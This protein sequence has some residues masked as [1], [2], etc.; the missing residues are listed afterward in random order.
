MIRRFIRYYKPHIKMFSA[1]M[2]CAFMLALCSLLLPNVTRTMINDYIPN[3]R[4]RHL[5]IAAGIL[6]CAYV[7]KWFLNY[8]IQYYGHVVGVRMQGQMR[9]EMFQKI[10]TLPFSFYDNNKTGALMSRMINDLFDVSE[11]AYHGPEDIFVSAVLLIGSFVGMAMMDIWLTLIIFAFIPFMLWFSAK[12]RVKMSR[13]FKRSREEVAEVN[14]TLENSISGV[15]VSKAF[16]N[17]DTETEKFDRNNISFM[18]SRK[19]AYKVMAEFHAG[20]TLIIDALYVVVLLAGGLFTYY[21]RINAG[22]FVAY[23]LYVSVFLDPIR[24]IIGFIE[25][26]QNAMSGFSRFLEIMDTEPEADDPDA[27]AIEKVRGEISFE[28]ISFSYG[29]DKTVLS[30]IT[31]QVAPGCKLALVGPSGGGKTTLCHLLPRF[32]EV[33]EGR[34]KV[35]GVDIRKI[36]RESLRK[37]IGI[38]QQDVFLFT[39]SIYDNILCGRTDATKEEVIEAAKMAN[40]HEFITALPEGYDTYI[41]ERG[42]K[43]SGGQKQRISIARVFLKNPPILILDEATSA[44]DNITEAAVQ[45][46]LE[47]LCHG[48]TTLVVAHRLSTVRNADEIVVLTDDGIAERGSHAELMEKDGIYAGL[49]NTQFETN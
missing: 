1:D 38:V 8:F 25:Q 4:I 43:L 26:Y 20:N 24:R 3:G 49:Y 2:C 39:G 33:G 30:H 35:D 16:C 13:A 29:D 10:E 22:D 9:R 32:Y 37:S 19:E 42:V 31:M 45:Q 41:G 46:S 34:I 6:L 48:R 28:D 11:L 23:L 17:I 27:V 18:D 44:L 36:T 7:L 47:S 12:K 40:I 21:G 15:R 5:F 14:A